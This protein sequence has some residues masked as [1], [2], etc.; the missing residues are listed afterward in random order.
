[1]QK[2]TY[3]CK[4]SCRKRHTNVK[5]DLLMQKETTH[6]RISHA[7]G[8]GKRRQRS[9]HTLDAPEDAYF[10]AGQ[11]SILIHKS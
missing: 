5:R 8:C 4:N 3:S 1:M 11:D 9:R 2:E 6:M 10:P 7:M